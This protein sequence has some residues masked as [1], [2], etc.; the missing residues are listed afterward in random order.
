MGAGVLWVELR[1]GATRSF[2]FPFPTY[3]H[4]TLRSNISLCF[5]FLFPGYFFVFPLL[6]FFLSSLLSVASL[7]KAWIPGDVPSTVLQLVF[8]SLR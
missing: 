6:L 1:G 8:V 7:Y 3:F 4:P 5:L 2:G